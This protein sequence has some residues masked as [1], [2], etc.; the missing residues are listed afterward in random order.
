MSKKSIHLPLAAIGVYE[1]SAVNFCFLSLSLSLSLSLITMNS[2]FIKSSKGLKDLL[3]N[4]GVFIK[5]HCP[6]WG[7]QSNK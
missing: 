3:F 7:L 2:Y 6:K 4:T 5:L 1:K